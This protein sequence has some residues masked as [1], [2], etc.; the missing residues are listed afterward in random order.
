MWSNLAAFA[1]AWPHARVLGVWGVCCEYAALSF[2][3]SVAPQIRCIA[4]PPCRQTPAIIAM[5]QVS[6]LQMLFLPGKRSTP[7]G[8]YLRTSLLLPPAWK[9]SSTR[10]PAGASPRKLPR[11]SANQQFFVALGQGD[12]G[13]RP[14]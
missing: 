2:V 11:S 3:Q 1:W 6:V 7:F 14:C 12:P 10:P 9:L 13:N 5:A 8:N 4:S